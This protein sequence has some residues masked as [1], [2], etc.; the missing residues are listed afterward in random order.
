M[1]PGACHATQ[2]G[3]WG[4]VRSVRAEQGSELRCTCVDV[5]GSLGAVAAARRIWEEMVQ[6]GESGGRLEEVVALRGESTRYVARL[7]RLALGVGSE[8]TMVLNGDGCYV[9]TGGTGAL[10]LLT[11]RWMVERGARRVVLLS[12]SGQVATNAARHWEWLQESEAAV[13]VVLCDVGDEEMVREVVH[14]VHG[15]ARIRGVVHTAGV[16]ADAMLAEQ[17]EEQGRRRWDHAPAGP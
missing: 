6:A 16:L 7:D 10:G 15:E 13:E 8:E 17:T 12:R 11:A 2:S 1:G 4:L 14:R 3:L 9:V 5:E